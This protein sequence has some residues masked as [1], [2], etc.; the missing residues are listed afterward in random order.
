MSDYTQLQC[1]GLIGPTHNYAG[2]G[3]GNVASSHNAA[4]VSHPRQ[5]ALQGLEKMRHV[6]GLGITQVILPPPLRPNMALLDQCGVDLTSAK[7]DLYAQRVVRAAWSASSM[8]AANA[9]TIT[10]APDS[11]D[12]RLHITP[13]NLVSSLHRAQEARE[14]YEQLQRI[15]GEVATV[16]EPLPACD[17]M[18][19]EGA[20]N[21][22]RLTSGHGQPGLE[23]F[24]YGRDVSGP[25][26]S[27]YPAR[28]TRHAWEALARQHRL[29]A[30]RVV[31][32]QQHPEAIDGGVFHNDVIAMSHETLMIYHEYTFLEEKAVID[33]IRQKASVPLSLIRISDEALPL[34][35][36]VA[37]YFFNSQLLSLGDG[38]IGVLA[39][40]E[41]TEYPRAHAALE[42]LKSDPDNPIA[43]IYYRDVRESMRNGGGPACLRLRVVL[44]EAEIAALPQPCVFSEQRYEALTSFIETHYPASLEPAQ[45]YDSGFAKE[46]QRVHTGLMTLFA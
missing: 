2:L 14:R 34:Q 6:H 8:W 46:M 44:Q 10:P 24:V 16:H 39:P 35:E 27:R 36:A 13:A 4:H 28:Q 41:V 19:D 25:A 33:E 38:R 30:S 37:S 9:A 26:P 45:L 21:H 1:D 32:A 12:G 20:A 29:P 31:M 5:A 22:M 15:F 23:V 40:M 7:N 43:E 17:L 3:V 18:A 11:A 42:R